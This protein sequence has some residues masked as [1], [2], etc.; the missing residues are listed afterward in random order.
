M[1]E[2]P[3]PGALA[4][5]PVTLRRV[6]RALRCMGAPR[7]RGSG[8]PWEPRGRLAA[9]CHEGAPVAGF[10]AGGGGAQGA[11][12]GGGVARVRRGAEQHPPAVLHELGQARQEVGIAGAAGAHPEPPASAENGV[13]TRLIKT[14]DSYK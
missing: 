3:L 11:L 6:G 10:Q 9:R 13:R 7:G 14:I 2:G 12:Q 4:R 1:G 8:R 5:R